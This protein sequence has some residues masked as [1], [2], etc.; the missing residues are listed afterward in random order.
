MI[1]QDDL[2]RILR[3]NL[4]LQ[5]GSQLQKSIWNQLRDEFHL[6][7]MERAKSMFLPF[8]ILDTRC[9]SRA[10]TGLYLIERGKRGAIMWQKEST[11]SLGA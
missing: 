7:K 11:L 6:R 9:F 4:T 8:L 5:Q 1:S 3:V 10:N 2:R